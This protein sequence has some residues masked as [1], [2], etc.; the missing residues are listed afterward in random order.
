MDNFTFQRRTDKVNAILHFVAYCFS[1]ASS[2]FVPVRLSSVGVQLSKRVRV[3][4]LCL[5]AH[6]GHP[7]CPPEW[8]LGFRFTFAV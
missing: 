8:C 5:L 2:S 6:N 7:L 4:D 1:E 3:S